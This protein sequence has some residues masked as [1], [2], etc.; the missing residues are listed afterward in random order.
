MKQLLLTF[1]L[2]SFLGCATTSRPTGMLGLSDNRRVVIVGE[3]V[4]PNIAL[5]YQ[6]KYDAM[7]WFTPSEGLIV[8][9]ASKIVH[10]FSQSYAMKTLIAELKSINYTVGRWEFIV[11]K[12][13][14][15][16]F[17][18]VLSHMPKKSLS[19]A[20]GTVILIDSKGNKAMEEQVMRVTDGNFF[21]S[22][23]F[24]KY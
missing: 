17:E 3:H 14:E 18:G 5:F 20:R 13:A 8:N 4:D 15:G 9:S 6:K 23:E 11:P 7:V 19:H 24:Q 1:F 21:V 16:Y 12:T 22:Y 2:L 10:S